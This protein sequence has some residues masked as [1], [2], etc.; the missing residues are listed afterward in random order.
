[1]RQG[2]VGLTPRRWA[3][4]LRCVPFKNELPEHKLERQL[5]RTIC[6]DSRSPV[7]FGYICAMAWGGQGRGHAPS[8][9][10]EREKIAALLKKL[11]MG[12]LSRQ[13]AFNLFS[14]SNLSGLGP[15]FFTKL[16]YFFSPTPAFYIMDQWTAKSVN[17][18]VGSNLVRMA[19]NVPSEYNK[20]GNYQVFCEE[21]DLM[22]GLMGVTGETIEERL[23]SWGG[24]ARWPWRAYVVRNW[25]NH[26]RQRYSRN[27]MHDIY[28]HIPH[29][30]F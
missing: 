3:E 10:A 29:C 15:S 7:L 19:G 22:A 20:G 17:L 30:D 13:R 18:L 23:F 9:W 14:E 6:T 28:P 26:P 12:R 16:L 8:A 4:Q 27:S 2:P 5:V 1:M 11:R 21:I 25:P 24:R